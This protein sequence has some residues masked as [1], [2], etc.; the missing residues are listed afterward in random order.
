MKMNIEILKE[1]QHWTLSQKIDHSLGVID[2]FRNQYDGKV[3]VS[4]SGGKDSV[5]ML[6]LVEVIIPQVKCVFVMTGCESPSVCR[7]I[8]EQQQHHNIDI[9][10]PKK[11]LKQVFAECGFPLVS[12]EVAHHIKQVRRNPDCNA[13]ND[14][15]NRKDRHGIPYRWRYLITE[16]Y[17]V[18]DRCC[19]WLKKQP[20]YDYTKRTGLHPF[21][22][23]TAAE[24]HMRTM[25]YLKRGG[26]NSFIEKKNQHPASWPLAIWTE[27]DVK[28]YIAD[29]HL[30]LPDIYEQ[31]ATRTGCMGC[32]FGAHIHGESLDVMQRLWPRWYDM[33]MNYENNGIRYGDALARM[34]AEGKHFKKVNNGNDT[35][36]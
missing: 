7:F 33:V 16:P 5:A 14:M 36:I 30:Q 22:G 19:Y 6:S 29:R 8:R 25:A 23:L 15:L 10:R 18:S 32:G 21:V 28:A 12:K 2:Q 13:S 34:I 9:I 11:T 26:C 27:S 31:G 24:S 17:D 1:R 35:S 20:A 3:Y 4:F